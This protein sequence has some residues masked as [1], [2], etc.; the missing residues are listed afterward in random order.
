MIDLS[1]RS[2][3]R[4]WLGTVLGVVFCVTAAILVD[5]TNFSSLP[6]EA[7][8]RALAVDIVLPTMLAGPLLFILL[9]QV[10]AL[11]IARDEMAVMAT[12]DSLT[13]ILNRGAFTMMVEAYLDR[14]L[15]TKGEAN[16]SLMIID[17][18]H[19]KAINDHYGHDTGD[20]ALRRIASSIKS[21]LRPADLVGRIGGEEFGVFLPDASTSH[22][23]HVAERLRKAVCELHFPGADE[24]KLSVSV[25]GVSFH[26]EGSY[27]RLFKVADRCLYTAKEHGRNQVKMMNYVGQTAEA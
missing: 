13:G 9:R 18:D 8:Q 12:T 5:S 17:A 19:F 11:A 21:V 6:P 24:H 26:G 15:N 3:T 1:V 4:V 23:S 2:R 14:V 16:G 20:E 22:A 7:L 10:R 25:G 27:D